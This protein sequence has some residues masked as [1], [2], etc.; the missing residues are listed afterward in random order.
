MSSIAADVFCIKKM[1]TKNKEV[2]F[3]LNF[4]YAWLDAFRQLPSRVNVNVNVNVALLTLYLSYLVLSLWMSCTCP[5]F[6]RLSS[7]CHHHFALVFNS[8][9]C[10][11]SSTTTTLLT[12]VLVAK[13]LCTFYLFFQCNSFWGFIFKI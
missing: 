5:S 6:L 2:S 9:W 13:A 10:M 4:H 8:M 12:T 1:W 3:E 11:S 7:H